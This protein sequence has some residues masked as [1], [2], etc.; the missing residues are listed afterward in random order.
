MLS[1]GSSSTK[2][3]GVALCQGHYPCRLGAIVAYNLPGCFPLI[4]R[5]VS[6][7]FNQDIRSKIVFPPRHLKNESAV[8]DW[9]DERERRREK[10][11]ALCFA[12][13]QEF[14]FVR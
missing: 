6:P 3:D 5:I 8:L 10:P 12:Q 9:L 13:I 4:W 11:F 7:W 1:S 14:G 2:R